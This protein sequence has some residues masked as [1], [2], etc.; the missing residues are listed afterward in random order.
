MES[1]SKDQDAKITSK[2][3]D[4]LAGQEEDDDQDEEGDDEDDE[5]EA[6]SKRPRLS[7][8]GKRGPAGRVPQKTKAD[9]AG[10]A[11]GGHGA[12]KQAASKSREPVSIVRKI[13]GD[14]IVD[15]EG[16]VLD[17]RD[18]PDE[19][20]DG[21][22]PVDV[23]ADVDKETD[24]PLTATFLDEAENSLKQKEEAI[25]VDNLTHGVTIDVDDDSAMEG[26]GVDSLDN[27]EDW[28]D[29]EFAS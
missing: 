6:D 16:N 20:V 4:G 24:T 13:D 18:N 27:V 25:L 11:E 12:G 23:T 8:T 9:T 17:K 15:E 1:F 21:D 14:T 10:G 3:A 5:D 22:D 19:E 7:K 29:I 26:L 2:K 28:A